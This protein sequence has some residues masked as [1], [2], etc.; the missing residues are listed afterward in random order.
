MWLEEKKKKIDEDGWDM[1][2]SLRRRWRPEK[3]NTVEL[4]VVVNAIGTDKVYVSQADIIRGW[5][6]FVLFSSMWFQIQKL[7]WHTLALPG[8]A[9]NQVLEVA[10]YRKVL[11]LSSMYTFSTNFKFWNYFRRKASRW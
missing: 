7:L 9:C 3:E 8:Y 2:A 5:W 1:N 4:P 6:C 11:F 10:T